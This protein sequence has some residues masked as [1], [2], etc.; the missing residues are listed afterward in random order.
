LTQFG[1][2]FPL[3]SKQ[4][5][6]GPAAHPLYAA[7]HAAIGI[8]CTPQWNFHKYLFDTQ[9][10]LCGVFGH[11][12]SPLDIELTDAIQEALPTAAAAAAA[13]TAAAPAQQ[14]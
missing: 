3:T 10:E 13:A 14:Q 12:S 5:V 9:G 6:I 4:H 2:T 7:V 1:V 11:M 8:E